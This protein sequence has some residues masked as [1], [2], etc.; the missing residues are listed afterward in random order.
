MALSAPGTSLSRCNIKLESF[1]K[2]NT[3]RAVYER[4]RAYEPCVVVSDT[5]KRVYMHAVLSDERVY[6][7]EFPPRTLTPA[8]S[9]RCVRD[10]QLIN[11]FPEF[12]SG[13]HRERCQHIR[14]TYIRE[15]TLEKSLQQRDT[16]RE[17][18]PAL[19]STA[20]HGVNG[21]PAPR[22]LLDGS[23]DE[24]QMLK[25]KRSAS[26]P[27]PETL[28]LPKVPHPPSYPRSATPSVFSSSAPSSP[29]DLRMKLS[30]PNQRRV[31]SVLTRLLRRDRVSSGE[32]KEAELHLYTVSPRSRL[33]LHLQSAWNSYIIRS[34]LILDPLYR[35]RCR[36][37]THS[38]LA[39]I[40]W[41]KTTCLFNQLSSEL[42]QAGNN[43]ESLYLL[44]QELKTAAHRDVMLRRLFWRSGE[45]CVF[46]V[47]FLDESLLSCR[48]V[49]VYTADQLLLGT[50]IVQTLAVMFRDTD[51][52]PARLNLLSADRGA[53]ASRMLL[54]LICDP[55]LQIKKQAD[56]T[57]CQ[58]Q[59][60]LVEYLDASCSLLFELLLL[61][62]EASKCSSVENFLSVG[63]MLRVLQQD[64]NL[65]P[66]ISFQA[67][68]VVLCLSELH[69]SP[70]TPLQS[71]LLF[72]RCRLLLACL[73]H[74]TQLAQ[75]LHHHFREEFRFAVKPSCVEEKLPPHFPISRPMVH[76]VEQILNHILHQ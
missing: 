42:L 36:P 6:L 16:R 45:V 27:N 22:I 23:T 2:R 1:L 74:D 69:E 71:V 62:N 4:I 44:L 75:H 37:L 53:L 32:E 73:Q 9:Y 39:G 38:T 7:T 28:G 43:V 19:R 13:K 70:L 35:Q 63:W 50:L 61:G 17:G 65:L 12:L 64:P 11:D 41:E 21:Y 55:E 31:G 57:D 34:T 48:S 24:V 29:P 25:T 10:I 30:D 47:Q 18:L 40:S 15:R 5:V 26:C 67:Q 49:S 33:Y 20:T 14:V 68:Q 51:F 66:Y 46:L 58:L 56:I 8:V 3:E 76:L 72:Q 52:E 54:S 60:L 59:D